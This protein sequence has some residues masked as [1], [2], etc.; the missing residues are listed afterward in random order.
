MGMVVLW[1]GTDRVTVV[2]KSV[3]APITLEGFAMPIVNVPLPLPDPFVTV[4]QDALDVA[5]HAS[6]APDAIDTVTTCA[7][8]VD[9]R[10]PAAP[11]FVAEKTRLVGVALTA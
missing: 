10:S 3:L 4:A 5:V 8:G 11:F 1:L 7:D 2:L 6:V 9:T